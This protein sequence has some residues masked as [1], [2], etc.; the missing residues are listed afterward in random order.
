M[1]EPSF[2]PGLENASLGLL[3][4]AARRRAKQVIWGWLEPF[5]LTPQQF[6]ILLVLHES[7]PLSL[8]ELAARVWTD[9]PTACRVV[10]TLTDRG[11]LASGADP[12]HGRRRC[13]RLAEKGRTLAPELAA[14]AR[15]FR[16]GLESGLGPAE[17]EGLR[18]SLKHVLLNLDLLE[19]QG[20][21]CE[22]LAAEL[23]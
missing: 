14:L 19:A 8:H 16:A 23:T 18:R 13:I 6:W 2:P 7:G 21:A 22:P 3:I 4:G 15:R 12:H 11:L 17:L 9:D 20:Q 5:G 1:Q 10:R